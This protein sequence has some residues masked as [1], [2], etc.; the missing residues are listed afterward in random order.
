MTMRLPQGGATQVTIMVEEAT[1]LH[2]YPRSTLTLDAATAGIVKWEP[3][4]SYNLGRT[5][6]TWVRPVHTGEAGG[7]SASSSR[8]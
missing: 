6:R 3:F 2:P 8:L 7:F 4:S 1:S 5:L